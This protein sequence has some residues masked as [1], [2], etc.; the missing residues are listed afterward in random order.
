M[1][2]SHEGRNR[3]DDVCAPFSTYRHIFMTIQ[4]TIIP[5]ARN[6]IIDWLTSHRPWDEG[7][8]LYIRYGH[9]RMLR[10]YFRNPETS[11]ARQMLIEELRKL[12]GLTE[13]Q[14]ALLPR[15]ARGA[16]RPA[17]PQNPMPDS[18][19]VPAPAPDPRT[20]AGA[21]VRKIERLRER[22]PFLNSPGCPDVLK[23]LTA[24]MLTAHHDYTEAHAALTALPESA[25]G[26]EPEMLAR[27]VVESY[28]TNRE[29]RSELDYYRDHGTILGQATAIREMKES[30]DISTLSDLDLAKKIQSAKVNLGKQ[31]KKMERGD[32]TAKAKAED[33]EERLRLLRLE[34]ETRKKK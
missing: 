3:R 15:L 24:D 7:V 31:R 28:I 26:S 6:E 1:N 17:Q 25:T 22:Y 10:R 23:V 16:G 32:A 12:A 4:T 27:R 18:P 30:E 11:T 21:V 5:S 8:L 13:R 33:W 20:P 34:M 2:I 14:L 29:I 19:A 9:N